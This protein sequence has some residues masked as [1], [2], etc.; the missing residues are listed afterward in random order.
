MNEE[1]I[2]SHYRVTVLKC[3]ISYKGQ[4]SRDCTSVLCLES[5]FLTYLCSPNYRRCLR[6]PKPSEMRPTFSSSGNV[7]AVRTTSNQLPIQSCSL[8]H[9][10]KNWCT[11]Q[12]DYP[13]SL[14]FRYWKPSLDSGVYFLV[15]C[16]QSICTMY[17]EESNLLLLVTC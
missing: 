5:C 9:R 6:H 15:K 4:M 14:T 16:L 13:L 12:E 11:W 3:Y 17:M 8:P 1:P 2:S 10:K 7:M